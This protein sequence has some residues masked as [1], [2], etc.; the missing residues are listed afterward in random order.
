MV[1][2]ARGGLD[3]PVPDGLA[4][5][6][7]HLTAHLVGTRMALTASDVETY[8]SRQV[9][10]HVQS[11]EEATPDDRREM[12]IQSRSFLQ[13]VHEVDGNPIEVLERMVTGRVKVVDMV[14]DEIFDQT[15]GPGA[16]VEIGSS[17]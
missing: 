13:K 2:G 7:E 15:P 9:K 6:G 11:V 12:A 4:D 10:G 5:D 1:G 16:G 3:G 8:V 14:V 17:R